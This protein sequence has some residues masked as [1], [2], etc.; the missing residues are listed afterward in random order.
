MNIS[1]LGLTVVKHFEGLR[2]TAYK[3]PVGIWTIG[4]GHTGDAAFEG[5]VITEAQAEDLLR[6]DMAD[7]EDAVARMIEVTPAQH[8]F[9]ALASFTF[10]VGGGA[11]SRS[12]L[13]RKLNAGDRAGAADEFLRWNK[14]RIGGELK[15]LPGLTRRRKAE[16]HLFV[17]GEV[18]LFDGHGVVDPDEAAPA[19]GE[20]VAAP[21][22]EEFAALVGSWNLRHFRP[23]ELLMLGAAHTT[24][25]SPA[26][27]RNAHPPR[28]LWDNIRPTVLAL[29]R[30]RVLL[31]APVHLLSVYRNEE[32]NRLVGG[33]TA[34]QHVQFRAADFYAKSLSGPSHW[35]S[36]L[37]DLR[38]QGAFAGG[39]G[40]YD[41]FVHVDCRGSNVD[42]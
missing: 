6:D 15:P 31:N 32:Y 24:A 36:V 13:R 30:L 16:R 4:Y 34:S 10:N 38:S 5:N 17:T 29:D 41:T 35:A 7:S 40:V 8:E 26:F 2:L 9:D 23:S 28:A 14:G 25:G 21:A 12:T 27:G 20:P 19:D 42:F 37:R 18:Q 22:V 1:G 39:I 3:D 11:V 33:A